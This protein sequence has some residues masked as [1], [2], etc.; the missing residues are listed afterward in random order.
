[1]NISANGQAGS[2]YSTINLP[3]QQAYSTPIPLPVKQ[4]LTEDQKKRNVILGFI[5]TSVGLSSIGILSWMVQDSFQEKFPKLAHKIPKQ[6]IFYGSMLSSLGCL[7]A[8][9]IKTFSNFASPNQQVTPPS[10]KMNY[11]KS[12]I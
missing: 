4:P 6:V 11:F 9:Y 8:A 12:T 7:V 3:Q 2:F 1:M 5:G 10:K